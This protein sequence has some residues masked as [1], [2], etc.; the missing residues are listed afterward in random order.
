M[1]DQST[2]T[3]EPHVAMRVTQ[4]MLAEAQVK[5]VTEQPLKSVEKAGRLILRLVTDQETYSAQVVHRRQG[6]HETATSPRPPA[7]A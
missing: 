4:A 7:R 2:W 3:C 5:V 1:K 6:P